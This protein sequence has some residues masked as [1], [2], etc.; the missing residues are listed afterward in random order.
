MA[1]E[2]LMGTVLLAAGVSLVAACASSPADVPAPAPAP[3]AAAAEAMPEAD[4]ATLAEKRFQEAARSYRKVDK[5]G[6]TMYCK[7]ESRSTA[8]FRACSASPSHSCGWKSSRWTKCATACV[9]AGVAPAVP[10]APG[11]AEPLQA[12]GWTSPGSLNQQLKATVIRSPSPSKGFT[13]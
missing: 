12:G 13:S 4:A 11:A 6:K 7:K 2:K 10:A 5:D 1:F 9:T 8:P 3:V